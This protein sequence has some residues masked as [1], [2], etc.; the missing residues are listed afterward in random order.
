MPSNG[1]ATVQLTDYGI[2][3]EDE[4]L[5]LLSRKT[6]YV[7]AKVR[8]Y[9]DKPSGAW[10]RVFHADYSNQPVA[11]ISTTTWPTSTTQQIA[12]DSESEKRNWYCNR[13]QDFKV[14]DK[15]MLF[16]SLDQGTHWAPLTDAESLTVASSIPFFVSVFFD[17]KIPSFIPAMKTFLNSSPFAAWTV[18]SFTLSFGPCAASCDVNSAT[19]ER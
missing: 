9:G 8:N 17:G 6:F 10:F 11:A 3:L 18:I 14:G 16:Y 12:P 2:A 7:K 4:N 1:E 19:C 5:D 13:T 15:I